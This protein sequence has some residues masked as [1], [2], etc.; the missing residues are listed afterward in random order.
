MGVRHRPEPTRAHTARIRGCRHTTTYAA[1]QVVRGRLCYRHACV[2]CSYVT[3][4]IP[5]ILPPELGGP[6]REV[7][8]A[9]IANGGSE[10]IVKREYYVRCTFLGRVAVYGPCTKEEARSHA[11][12]TGASCSGVHEIVHGVSRYPLE[13]EPCDE[14]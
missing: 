5:T 7:L 13:L 6:S 4:A 1:N 8:Q 12:T 14:E 10:G 2:N 9:R 3:V 11:V